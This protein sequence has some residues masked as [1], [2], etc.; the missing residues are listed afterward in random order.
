MESVCGVKFYLTK[1]LNKIIGGDV[2]YVVSLLV[3]LVISRI[4]RLIK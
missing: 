3:Q 2:F 1:K 4:D